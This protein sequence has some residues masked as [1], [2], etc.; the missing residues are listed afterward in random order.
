MIS[1]LTK[2]LKS[3]EFVGLFSYMLLNLLI[4][5]M[6]ILSYLAQFFHSYST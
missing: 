6:G 1:L 2:K 5:F 4:K 3:I